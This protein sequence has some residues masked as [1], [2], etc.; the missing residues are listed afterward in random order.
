VSR[1]ELIRIAIEHYI[2]PGAGEDITLDLT[3]AK[4]DLTLKDAEIAS[5]KQLLTSKEQEGEVL[6][7]DLT[8]NIENLT[9]NLI[10]AKNDITLKEGEVAH[11]KQLLLSKEQE[12]EDITLVKE[13]LTLAKKE[14]DQLRSEQDIRWKELQQLRNELNQAKREIEAAKS[15]ENQLISERDKA[16][17]SEDQTSVELMVLRRDLEHFKEALRLKDDDISFLRGHL[18]QISEKLPKSLPPSEEEAKAKH[19]YQFWK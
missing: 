19:W 12:G 16:K 5:L 1:S 13:N 7:K 11:L 15:K 4:D 14:R 2:T 6:T 3:K 10:L 18:S 8:L 17:S 9:Q